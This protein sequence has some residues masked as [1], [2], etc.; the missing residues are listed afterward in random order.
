[1]G[2][3]TPNPWCRGWSD[4]FWITSPHPQYYVNQK[5]DKLGRIQNAL[6][7]TGGQLILTG[8][9]Q[10][11]PLILTTQAGI[12]NPWSMNSY[13]QKKCTS[14]WSHQKD[15]NMF[16]IIIGVDVSGKDPKGL[17]CI[18]LIESNKT[19]GKNPQGTDKP[20]SAPDLVIKF[21]SDKILFK[22][23]A[24]FPVTVNK[25]VNRINLIHYNVQRLANSTRDVVE[26]VH[27]QLSQ[28]SLM[29]L[30]NRVALD[31]LLA[32][33]GGVCSMFDDLCCTVIANNSA[34]DGTLTK[35]LH[36]LRA[37]ADEM[38]AQ[39]GVSNPVTDWLSNTFGRWGAL[40]GQLFIGIAI[41][42]SIFITCGCCCIPC[43]RTLVTRSIER[44]LAKEE[45]PK[46]QAVVME[47][48]QF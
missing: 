24:I 46:Y 3:P 45:P 19:V 18:D 30:Q 12:T 33:K 4:V 40:I 5:S 43:I 2:Y 17:I 44:A 34:P 36:K 25:N 14:T 31:M 11:N 6:T 48:S 21:E 41:A 8:S 35:G 16:Y 37:L 15:K 28:T 27:Q 9:Q 20:M 42:V 22:F 10:L 7:L 47:E 38:K 32:E 29:A 26:A 39:S 23:S 1:M 13:D